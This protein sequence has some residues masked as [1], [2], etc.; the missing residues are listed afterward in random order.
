MRQWLKTK[1]MS[2]YR[3]VRTTVG[4][5]SFSIVSKEEGDNLVKELEGELLKNLSRKTSYF[6]FRRNNVQNN[7]NSFR[8]KISLLLFPI[9][10]PQK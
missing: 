7:N 6:R 3:T 9:Y 10:R 1:Y 2:N 5:F 4:S 8:E